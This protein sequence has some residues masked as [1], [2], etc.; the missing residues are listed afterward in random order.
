MK[1]LNTYFLLFILMFF[2][3]SKSEIT[4]PE[5]DDYNL[6]NTTPIADSTMNI[7]EGIYKLAGGQGG[8]GSEFVCK[9]SRNRVTFFSNS[10]G[11]F[12]ILKFGYKS[13]DGSIQFSGFWRYSE[14]ADQGKIHLSMTA[15][16]GASQLLS[17][18]LSAFKIT[19]DF[20]GKD[21]SFQFSREFSDFTK[22]NEF[23]IFGHH[24]VQTTSN[25]PYAENS[26]NGVL[27]DEGYGVNG[28]EYDVRM[29]KDNVPI[30]IHDPTINTRLTQK[31][32]LSG[33]WDQYPYLFLHSYIRLIDGQE[34]PSVEKVLEYFVDST[35]LK[36]IWL[37]IKGNTDIFK[38]LE[39]IVRNAY[40]SATAQ[41]RNVEIFVGLPSSAVIDEYNKQPS[42]KSV[43]TDYPY[44]APLPSLCEE[45]VEKAIVNGS[46]F[47]GPRFS[48]G[49]IL[50]QVQ[51]AHDNGIKVISWT[52]NSR[53]LILDY[54]QNGKF[55]GFIT[56]Y[57]AYVNYYYYTLF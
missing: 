29:T 21:V 56:D 52:L 30:C 6:I 3:C 4:L 10:N 54:M 24:G 35:T 20:D 9:T 19:G 25:P 57:P 11:I 40:Q 33:S 22:N 23:M 12:F 7:M 41:G 8:L 51:R 50:D 36:Y 15:A 47:F 44:S 55:D 42:Y 34:L 13:A 32:P 45:S 28:L 48:N 46:K 39:P 37:D 43:N 5:E 2:S 31:G 14:T 1:K 17:G 27:F 16:D 53:A 26:L 18:N 49:L 38:Y